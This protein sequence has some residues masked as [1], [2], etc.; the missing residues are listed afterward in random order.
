MVDAPRDLTPM[1]PAQEATL[2][3]ALAE[4]EILTAI[5]VTAAAEDDLGGILA[6]A[7]NA[8][9]GVIAFTGGSIAVVEED[10]L[11]IRA[12]VGLFAETAMG[13]SLPRGRGRSWE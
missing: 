3:R 12:A 1:V 9:Q 5:A 4:A 13:Q 10:A 7:L 6:A 8:I 2:R 11:V